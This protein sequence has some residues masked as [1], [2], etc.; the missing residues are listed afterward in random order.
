MFRSRTGA[1]HVIKMGITMEKAFEFLKR[2]REVAFATVEGDRPKIRVFQIMKQEKETL[3]FVPHRA[4]SASPKSGP[5]RLRSE[6]CGRIST[7]LFRPV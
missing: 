5:P 4:S 3:Y 7:R 6:P 2:N 1:E